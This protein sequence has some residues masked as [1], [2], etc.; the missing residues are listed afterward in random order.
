M[1]LSVRT[2]LF[3]GAL[4]GVVGIGHA[5]AESGSKGKTTPWKNSQRPYRPYFNDPLL[6]DLPEGK[7]VESRI[8]RV[9]IYDGG[10]LIE[11]TADVKFSQGEQ[12]LVFPALPEDIVAA[13]LQISGFGATVSAG[14]TFLEA[15]TL[16]ESRP[17]AL[18]KLEEALDGL[19]TEHQE[20]GNRE[21]VL[22]QR[23]ELVLANIAQLN[24]GGATSTDTLKKSL[25]F[26]EG[27]LT[28]LSAELSDIERQRGVL[29]PRIEGLQSA[30]AELISS[31]QKPVKHVVVEANARSEVSLRLVMR[32]VVQGPTWV[33]RHVGHYDPA[34]GRLRLDTYAWIVQ[35]TPE[36]WREVP[37]RVST[38][39][40][41]FGL[42]APTPGPIWVDLRKNEGLEAD[43]SQRLREVAPDSS[44]LGALGLQQFEVEGTVTVEPGE[45]GRRVLLKSTALDADSHHVAA[46]GASSG[47]YLVMGITNPDIVPW[48]PG[49]ASLFN[50]SDYVGTASIPAVLPGEALV[51][52]YGV[53][54]AVTLVRERTANKREDD[55]R[56]QSIQITTRYA[57]HN[58]LSRPVRLVV[59]EQIPVARTNKMRINDRAEGLDFTEPTRN[60]PGG[61]RLWEAKVPPG[62]PLTWTL[63]LEISAP[64]DQRI[65]GLD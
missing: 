17:D 47:V 11:R 60:S 14:S 62:A 7:V 39:R 32:Y 31:L 46:P 51:L 13:T 20:L 58:S 19:T 37:M 65:L 35:R 53:D 38:A 54:P 40:P 26:A 64:S 48:L 36:A 12:R 28:A 1:L 5:E 22:G 42:K 30:H 8:S 24:S 4:I 27:E 10:A 55:G 59:R 49:E 63:V 50:G 45:Q 61:A 29:E 18:I 56:R 6:R 2:C 44:S 15:G 3:M 43:E 33:P 23:R 34:T 41:S 52:P 16:V 25:D 21:A 57:A 9:E